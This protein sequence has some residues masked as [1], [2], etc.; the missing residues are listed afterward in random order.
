MKS[1]GKELSHD[2]LAR[3]RHHVRRGGLP[4]QMWYTLDSYKVH[5]KQYEYPVVGL[6]SRRILALRL[7]CLRKVFGQHSFKVIE[8]RAC[9]EFRLEL[10]CATPLASM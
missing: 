2:Q 10:K 3:S 6:S 5:W 9:G 1:Q 7:Y 4:K 8:Q